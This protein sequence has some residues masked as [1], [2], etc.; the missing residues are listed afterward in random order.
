MYL[1]N[2]TRM[3]RACIRS[4]SPLYQYRMYC[5]RNFLDILS[6]RTFRSNPGYSHLYSVHLSCY[7]SFRDS[8]LRSEIGIGNGR[9]TKSTSLSG[10]R[11]CTYRIYHRKSRSNSCNKVYRNRSDSLGSIL[12]RICSTAQSG[13]WGNR[14]APCI[15]HNAGSY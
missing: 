8:F 5:F 9:R 11:K 6:D 4:H 3:C 2:D 1:D 13:R 15:P 12:A 7:T 10:S 14:G